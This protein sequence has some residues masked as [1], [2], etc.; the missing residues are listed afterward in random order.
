MQ[1]NDDSKG[2]LAM[3]KTLRTDTSLAI[4][5]KIHMD[6]IRHRRQDGPPANGSF[7]V[8]LNNM[9]HSMLEV[10]EVGQ[11]FIILDALVVEY[12]AQEVNQLM[13]QSI[14]QE[15]ENEGGNWPYELLKE[16]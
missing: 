6:H 7:L 16:K 2:V 12:L 5:A 4:G 9:Q 14:F 11:Q 8:Y 10:K 3:R 1:D 15:L 13:F